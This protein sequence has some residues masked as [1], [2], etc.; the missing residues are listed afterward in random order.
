MFQRFLE[1]DFEKLYNQVGSAN[2]DSNSKQ[3]DFLCRLAEIMNTS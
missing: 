2:F 3:F 1:K